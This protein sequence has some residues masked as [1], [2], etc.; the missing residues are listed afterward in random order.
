[1]HSTSSKGSSSTS[2]DIA[3][4]DAAD[5]AEREPQDESRSEMHE[6]QI[7]K[8]E[9]LEANFDKLLK[10][11][12]RLHRL[13]K[14]YFLEM[15]LTE[16]ETRSESLLQTDDRCWYRRFWPSKSGAGDSKNSSVLPLVN[17]T[18]EA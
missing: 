7:H 10:D 6:E 14:D 3:S 8:V 4:L 13:L 2:S 11:F 9:R 12:Q 17:T 5:V 15:D 1:M 18:N 16:G